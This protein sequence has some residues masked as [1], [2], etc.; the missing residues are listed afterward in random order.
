MI[1]H[2]YI[3][4]Q[5]GSTEDEKGVELQDVIVQVEANKL[6]TQLYFHIN[7]QGG[8]VD[9]GKLIADYISK[10]PNAVTIAEVQCASMGTEIHLSVPLENRKMIAG[11]EYFIHNPLLVGVNGNA[12]ELRRAADNIEP[13]QKQMLS[14]YMKATG[15]G[16]P[17]LEGLMRQETSLT[18]EECKT[19]GFVSEIIPRVELKAV[20]FLN[21]VNKQNNNKM[22]KTLGEKLDKGLAEIKALL[23][24]KEDVKAIMIATDKGELSYAS[25]GEIPAVGEEVFIGEDVAPN[26]SYTIENGTVIVVVDGLVSEIVE[27]EADATVE[28]LNAKIK[29]LTDNAASA[30]ANHSKAIEELKVKMNA[31]FETDIEAKLTEFKS[32]ISSTHQVQAAKKT[33]NKN[34][35]PKTLSF[36]EKIQAK[37]EETK[38]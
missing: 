29:E 34:A 12:E 31:K 30:D 38:K 21:K 32:T 22:E 8:S 5:I 17:A 27:V 6:A 33:F 3:T 1:G 26:D 18:D 4:G 13:V 24:K 20:A 9:T 36:K 7:S 19:L 11:T 15:L 37:R 2:I 14:M 28:E 35:K 16:K 10:I 25:E 23:T